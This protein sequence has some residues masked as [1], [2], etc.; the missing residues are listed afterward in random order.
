MTQ[1][2]YAV[3]YALTAAVLT[4]P[5]TA[6]A[7]FWPWTS[8]QGG[9]RHAQSDEAKQRQESFQVASAASMSGSHI[10]PDAKIVSRKETSIGTVVCT[11]DGVCY[12]DPRVYEGN[13]RSEVRTARR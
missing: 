4:I 8:E 13:G 12:L 1:R 10:P 11:S 7:G 2:G 5:M 9:E 6:L 3:L